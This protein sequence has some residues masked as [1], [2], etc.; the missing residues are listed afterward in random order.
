MPKDHTAPYA[1]TVEMLRWQTGFWPR[2]LR[3]RA[4]LG[5]RAYAYMMLEAAFGPLMVTE[6]QV[7]VTQLSQGFF[8]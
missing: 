7:A 2:W 5:D 1:Q 8:R 3:Q 6:E 4:E